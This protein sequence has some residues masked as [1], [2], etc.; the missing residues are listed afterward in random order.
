[1][2]SSTVGSS[3]STFWKRR[4]SA[5]SFSM[6]LRYSSS[7]VAP[8]QCSSPRAS[9]GL[10]MLPASMAPSALP[11]PTMVCSSS[12]NR[13]IWPSCLD[14]IVEHALEALF[15]FAAELGARDQRAHVQRQ[16]ALV[17]EH[18]RH[19]AV[20]D[21]LGE[22]FDNG[23][24]A[25]ARLADEHRIVLGAA[26]EHLDR[27]A[28]FIVAAD[29]RI[30]L[31]AGGARREIDGELLERAALLLG[32]RIVDGLAA[33]NLV[34]GLFDGGLGGAS[35]LQKSCQCVLVL[36]GRER[37]QLG[38]DVVVFALLRELVRDI[39]QAIEVL[40]HVDVTGRA[41]HRGQF[42]DGRVQVLAQL[43]DVR[44]G[45][46][47]QRPGGAVLLVEQRG[48]Y[49]RGLHELVVLAHGQGLGVG[50]G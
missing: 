42:V 21:A 25:H 6:Y 2:V 32:L 44:A 11:A 27:A 28:D 23:G 18:L 5:A 1:M 37:E 22:T 3:T 9:A 20:D 16:D 30:Q 35:L 33:A 4:S 50:Q 39:E 13:M 46:H 10:S 8:T 14:E 17:L 41:L 48:E 31:A 34:D 29:D 43:G 36:E 12:M 49:M 45:L 38:R 19:F 7:V 26:R 40:R 15:E 24:L 47:Q